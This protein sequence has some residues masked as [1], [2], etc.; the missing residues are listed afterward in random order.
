[1]YVP[2]MLC[3]LS[4]VAAMIGSVELR[5]ESM[6]YLPGYISTAAMMKLS[7]GMLN[8]AFLSSMTSITV[9]FTPFDSFGFTMRP[10]LAEGSQ[11]SL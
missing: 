8:S 3:S 11:N 6:T 1:M 2:A 7:W 5:T 10:V 4:V 9:I